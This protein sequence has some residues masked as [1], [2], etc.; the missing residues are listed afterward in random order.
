MSHPRFLA[1]IVLISALFAVACTDSIDTPR[2]ALLERIE[3]ANAKAEPFGNGT[4]EVGVDIQPGIYTAQRDPDVLVGTCI[5]VRIGDAESGYVPLA[6]VFSDNHPTIIEISA[7]DTRFRSAY[8]TEWEPYIPPAEP[9][10]EFG[11]GA[12]LVGSDVRPGLYVAASDGTY[13]HCSWAMPPGLGGWPSDYDYRAAP[14]DS[15][16][17]RAIVELTDAGVVFDSVGCSTWQRVDSL[18]EIRRW[19]DLDA[20]GG[21]PP[22]LW[23]VGREIEPGTYVAEQ[24][25]DA[26]VTCNWRRLSG[27]DGTIG[28]MLERDE[29]G[30]DDTRQFLT[31]VIEDGDVAFATDG[32]TNWQ[33]VDS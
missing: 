6:S 22:G 3:K 18:D 28:S 30:I 33:R 4:W 9:R 20:A 29:V 12:V 11:T 13:S 16:P 21:I 10:D 17:K 8:C 25:W 32:C 2:S 31:V 26:A 27:F 5:G 19:P 7:S 24:D 23:L 15:E 1:A 14:F